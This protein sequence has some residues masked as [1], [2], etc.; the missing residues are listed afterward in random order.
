MWFRITAPNHNTVTSFGTVNIT[1]RPVTVTI[2]NVDT[3]KVTGVE[4]LTC[5]I[6]AGT[7]ALGE[8]L[9]ILGITLTTNKLDKAG[10]YEIDGT[11]TNR[12]Y[13]VTFVKG[14]YTIRAMELQSVDGSIVFS[15]G[16]GINPNTKVISTD[17]FDDDIA[18]IDTASIA[19]RNTEVV[20]AYN[21]SFTDEHGSAINIPQAVHTIKLKIDK[22]YRDNENFVVVYVMNS[23][24][25]IDVKAERVGNY[26]V[27]ESNLIGDYYIITDKQADY[28]VVPTVILS[29]L[30]VG[31]I[32]LYVLQCT[33]FKDSEIRLKS[34]NPILLSVFIP[35]GSKVAFIIL[36]IACVFMIFI[37][38]IKFMSKISVDIDFGSN[39]T[40]G[41]DSETI[42]TNTTLNETD[43][44]NTNNK[45]TNSNVNKKSTSKSKHKQTKRKHKRR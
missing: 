19:G 22:E 37:N 4:N 6:T 39:E 34:V 14:T 24:V 31:L 35:F 23:V 32:V 15:T 25:F 5:R 29:I 21:L 20:Q 36:L 8:S 38:G 41:A 27:F 18:I 17:V 16:A 30:L 33:K 42:E 11:Y 3:T 13:E 28:L 10:V 2:D 43:S 7:L 40:N 9:P 12:N 1:K 26:L 45:Q 44:S